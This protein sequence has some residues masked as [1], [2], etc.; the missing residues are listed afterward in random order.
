[1]RMNMT[2]RA[3]FILQDADGELKQW[4]NES[5]ARLE[6]GKELPAQPFPAEPNIFLARFKNYGLV[7][8]RERDAVEIQDILN[9]Q[10]VSQCSK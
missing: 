6:A 3:R 5:L 9:L 4:L 8:K 1:M 7:F 2:L 10:L